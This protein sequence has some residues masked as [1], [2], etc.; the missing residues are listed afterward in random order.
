[1]GYDSLYCHVYVNSD[2]EREDLY[3]YINGKVFGKLDYIR[4]RVAGI[5]T[6]WGG[7]ELRRNDEFNP[8]LLEQDSEDFIFWRYHLDI[9]AKEG[10]DQSYYIARVAELLRT[11]NTENMKAVASCDFEEEL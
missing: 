9:N 8:Q 4:G 5:V 10:I 2:L 1:M 11:L 7:M 3:Q 6:D